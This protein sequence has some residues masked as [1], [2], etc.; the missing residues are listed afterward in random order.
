M[1]IDV[2]PCAPEEGEAFGKTISAAFGHEPNPGEAERYGKVIE[3]GRDLG[4][5]EDGALVGTATAFSFVLTVPGGEARAAGVTAVGVLPSH[6][7]RGILT[8]LMRR[9]LDD[10]R[11]REEPL[12][13]L[14]AS[15]GAIYGRFGYGVATVNARLSS[16]RHRGVFR[17][18]GPAAGRMR[19][20]DVDE[21]LRMLPDVYERARRETPGFYVRTLDW[22]RYLK[23]ADPE[24]ERR[25]GGIMF[26]A[27]L[28]LEGRPEAYALYRIH[29]EGPGDRLA[30]I[31]EVSTSPLS[32]REIWRFLFGVDLIERVTAR[33]LPPDHP[34]FLLAVEPG[35]LGLTLEEGL[36]LRMVDVGAALSARSY[37]GAGGIVFDVADA[38][39]PWNQGRW[40]LE[41]G[42]AVRTTADP[43]LRL[44][45][46]DLA[47]AYLGGFSFGQL[48]RAGRVTELATG[49]V[50]RADA[51]FRTD[52]APWC[53]ETF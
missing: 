43:D 38:F 29:E 37:A 27:V 7:R 45:V 2:R 30:V 21:A 18:P 36:W 12:A 33:H 15:E 48:T 24:H 26:R 17:D 34:L 51:L 22:W 28:E 19:L 47:S 6:R 8:R 53:P 25:G 50:A 40:R 49:A 10:V 4:A 31:E 13:I 52:R 41:E 44:D 5:Y 46:A 9:Q 14:W 11:E 16:E 42:Q 20:L 3:P 35:R 32:T 1:Q 23:L 39:C